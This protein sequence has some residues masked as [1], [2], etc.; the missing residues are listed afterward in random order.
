MPETIVRNGRRYQKIKSYQP[1][2]RPT[3][4]KEARKAREFGLLARV[5]TYKGK[6]TLYTHAKK[7]KVKF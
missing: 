7:R 2:N 5:E 1:D 6:P 3:A 4:L